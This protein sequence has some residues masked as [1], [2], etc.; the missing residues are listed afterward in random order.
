[1]VKA[2]VDEIMG[3]EKES[4]ITLPRDVLRK[5][6]DEAY[7]RGKRDALKEMRSKTHKAADIGGMAYKA[8]IVFD[9]DEDNE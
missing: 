2:N 5:F 8:N 7:E 6:I 9:E 4:L 1:M 3:D